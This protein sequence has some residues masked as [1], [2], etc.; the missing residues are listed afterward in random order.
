MSEIKSTHNNT[1]ADTS[2]SN[3]SSSL[4]YLSLKRGK[5]TKHGPRSTGYVQYR[6]LS[7]TER[8]QLFLTLTDNDGGG[9]FSKEIVP[10]ARV[11]HC[12]NGIPTDKPVA[13][14][15]FQ[16][17]F[18]GKSQNNAGFLVAVL[19]SEQLLTPAPDASHLHLVQPHWDHWQRTLL[20]QTDGAEPYTPEPPKPRGGVLKSQAAAA[21]KQTPPETT[22]TSPEDK[23]EVS[24][25]DSAS[26]ALAS[27]SSD[28]AGADAQSDPSDP[29][30]DLD[31]AELALLQCSGDGEISGQDDIDSTEIASIRTVVDQRSNKRQPREKLQRP[32]GE[33]S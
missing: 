27:S 1:L 5:A 6:I 23:P 33:R 2:F 31:E 14:K 25:S 11:Q 10:F 18:A 17:A 29:Q 28:S 26:S 12:L 21:S 19:R 7:D 30:A 15:I 16:A 24:G 32:R 4:G 9:C 20:A 3:P 22:A 13:S 8:Q